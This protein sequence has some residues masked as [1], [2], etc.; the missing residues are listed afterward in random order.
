MR[1]SF[2]GFVKQANFMNR[3]WHAGAGFKSEYTEIAVS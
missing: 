2:R 1:L 3:I